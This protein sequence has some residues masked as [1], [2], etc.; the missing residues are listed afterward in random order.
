MHIT[1]IVAIVTGLTEVIKR[2]GL[3]SK[4]APLTAIAIGLIISFLN[5]GALP[6]DIVIMTGI[7]AGLTSAGLYSG[8]KAVINK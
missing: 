5:R 3:P 1:L 2:I 7:V 6:I 4:F 8:T